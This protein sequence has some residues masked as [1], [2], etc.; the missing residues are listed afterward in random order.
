MPP[1]FFGGESKLMQVEHLE[2]KVMEVCL[3]QMTSPPEVQQFAPE[4]LVSRFLNS[5]CEILVTRRINLGV[6]VGVYRS[7]GQ[8]THNSI[9]FWYV[10]LL[11]YHTHQPFM[12]REIYKI[13]HGLS[14]HGLTNNPP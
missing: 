7:K 11:I 5:A 4:N 8:L 3:V 9:R 10:Y 6:F 2:P 1:I 13:H 12:D 14:L